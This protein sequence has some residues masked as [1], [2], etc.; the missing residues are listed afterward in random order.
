MAF[1][2]KP[3]GFQYHKS[4]C[5]KGNHLENCKNSF[6]GYSLNYHNEYEVKYRRYNN[7]QLMG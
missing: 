1:V 3:V 5:H 6:I 4:L 7:E 2:W